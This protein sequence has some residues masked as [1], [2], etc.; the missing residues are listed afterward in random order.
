[1]AIGMNANF[2]NFNPAQYVREDNTLS[3]IGNRFANVAANIPRLVREGERWQDERDARGRAQQ[4]LN[5]DTA[6]KTELARRMQM[7]DSGIYAKYGKSVFGHINPDNYNN[8]KDLTLAYAN[9]LDGVMAEMPEVVQGDLLRMAVELGKK[10]DAQFAMEHSA[11]NASKGGQPQTAQEQGVGG[12]MTQQVAQ[13]AQEQQPPVRANRFD[14]L[15]SASNEDALAMIQAAGEQQGGFE[16]DPNSAGMRNILLNSGDPE[17]RTA[18]I[19]IQNLPRDE[20]PQPAPPA[21]DPMASPSATTTVQPPADNAGGIIMGGAVQTQGGIP[22]QSAGTATLTPQQKQAIA[23]YDDMIRDQMAYIEYLKANNGIN[24]T[25]VH[26]AEDRLRELQKEQLAIKEDKVDRFADAKE[27][28]EEEKHRK[29][30]E[31]ADSRIEKNK[32]WRPS[33]GSGERQEFNTALAHYDRR[34]DD[35]ANAKNAVASRTVQLNSAIENNLDKTAV[36]AIQDQLS[37]DEKAYKDALNSYATSF[38]YLRKTDPKGSYGEA[39]QAELRNNLA[40][41]ARF[42]AN[43]MVDNLR[44]LPMDKKTNKFSEQQQ[45]YIKGRVAHIVDKYGLDKDE[46]R[47]LL[48]EITKRESDISKGEK[49]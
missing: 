24:S 17:L 36:S 10:A 22:T 18:A 38:K 20:Y 11:F 41:E 45:K 39:N 5:N 28:R 37:V 2:G 31:E 49:R 25:P 48:A 4:E 21:L 23:M 43:N 40:I 35:V 14:G 15:G 13:T 33:S 8:T 30:M 29:A 3:S 44:G 16:D 46:A 27:R 1:M 9:A 7:L 19:D 34:A 12:M 47:F 42:V 6:Q 26:K 32:K